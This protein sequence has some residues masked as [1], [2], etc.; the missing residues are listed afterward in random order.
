MKVVIAQ[1]KVT[2]ARIVI[3]KSKAE[4]PG[5]RHDY[6]KYGTYEKQ[7]NGSWKRLKKG[8]PHIR[9]TKE[10]YQAKAFLKSKGYPE[11]PLERHGIKT[12]RSMIQSKG[13]KEEFAGWLKERKNGQEIHE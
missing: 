2:D 5:T 11:V 9:K 7:E 1:N 10:Y 6:G 13:W 12:Y 4:K 8:Y 3:R